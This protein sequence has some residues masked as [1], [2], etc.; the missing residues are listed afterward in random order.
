MLLKK[1][2]QELQAEGGPITNEPWITLFR[3]M[4]SERE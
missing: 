1:E 2:G 4:E 3:K